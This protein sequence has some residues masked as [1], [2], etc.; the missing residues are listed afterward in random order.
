MRSRIHIFVLAL[1]AGSALGT[2]APALADPAAIQR[3]DRFERRDRD[4]D[5]RDRDDDRRDRRAYDQGFQQGVREGEKDARRSGVYDLDLPNRKGRQGA[6]FDSGF[7]AGYRAGFERVRPNRDTR[8]NR[9]YRDDRVFRGGQVYGAPSN[10]AY[11]EPASA[12]GYSDGY[13]RGLDDARHRNRYDPVGEKDYRN[14]DDGY[15]NGYGSKDAYKNN[16]RAGFRQGYEDG[17]RGTARR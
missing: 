2:A 11:R 4:D 12:R 16:Y 9:V 5:R 7:A 14:G 15:Y 8:D 1:L 6:D 3:D 13:E 10:G 17:Y